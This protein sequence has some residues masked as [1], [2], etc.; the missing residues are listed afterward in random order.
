MLPRQYLIEPSNSQYRI[1]RNLVVESI[2]GNP[3]LL[4][5]N[6]IFQDEYNIIPK[7]FGTVTDVQTIIKNGKK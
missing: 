3:E 2:Q 7:S 6:T 5:N 1:T 4:V